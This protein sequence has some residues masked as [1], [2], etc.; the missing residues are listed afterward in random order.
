M[1]LDL[2]VGDVQVGNTADQPDIWARASGG[3]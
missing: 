2:C 3:I 1:K